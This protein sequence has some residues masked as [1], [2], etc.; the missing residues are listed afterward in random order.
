MHSLCP[1]LVLAALHQLQEIAVLHL[2]ER[3]GVAPDLKE[4]SDVSMHGSGAMNCIGNCK[5]HRKLCNTPG[6]MKYGRRR[7]VQRRG[8]CMLYGWRLSHDAEIVSAIAMRSVGG[9]QCL[10]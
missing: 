4:A 6:T 1:E 7:R 8:T 5:I 10:A 2:E 9:L 3:G